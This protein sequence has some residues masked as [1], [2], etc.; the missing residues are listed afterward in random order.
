MA[1][2]KPIIYEISVGLKSTL[3]LRIISIN[4]D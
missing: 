3:A 2:A 1:W 4:E